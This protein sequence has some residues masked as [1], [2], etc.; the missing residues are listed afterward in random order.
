[1]QLDKC[2]GPISGEKERDMESILRLREKAS[3]ACLNVIC[4]NPRER[5][6]MFKMHFEVKMP[7]YSSP[8][9]NFILLLWKGGDIVNLAT[10]C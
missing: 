2:E 6:K 9:P 5:K 3:A 8:R 10:S 7:S 4:W 1:M